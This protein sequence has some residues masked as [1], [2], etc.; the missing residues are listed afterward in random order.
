VR[1][2]ISFNISRMLVQTKSASNYRTSARVTWWLG[3]DVVVVM[4]WR[5]VGDRVGG[6]MVV[7]VL[8]VNVRRR[9]ARPEYQ[10]GWWGGGVGVMW[11]WCGGGTWRRSFVETPI[12]KILHY[13][14]CI[15]ISIDSSHRA[16]ISPPQNASPPNRSMVPPSPKRYTELSDGNI[17]ILGNTQPFI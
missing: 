10:P 7:V 6:M 1:V 8:P 15:Y 17:Y 12:Q 3:G 11:R 16:K 13:E 14:H 5:W 4:W 2:Q 9:A